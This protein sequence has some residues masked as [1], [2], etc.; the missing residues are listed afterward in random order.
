MVEHIALLISGST[1]TPYRWIDT[2]AVRYLIPLGIP[3]V[4]YL[5]SIVIRFA[6]VR[7]LKHRVHS[8]DLYNLSP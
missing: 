2:I 6:H 1:A 8:A 7:H 5:N 4:Q 3:T